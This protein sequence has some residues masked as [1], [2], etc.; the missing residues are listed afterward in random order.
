MVLVARRRVRGRFQFLV[1]C[2]EHSNYVRL[3]GRIDGR[4]LAVRHR[5]TGRGPWS[6]ESSGN[7]RVP[8]GEIVWSGRG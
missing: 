4:W 2:P 6:V 7:R 8:S 5:V 1:V 3:S